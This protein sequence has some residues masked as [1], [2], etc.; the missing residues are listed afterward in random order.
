MKKRRLTP[1]S[2]ALKD[3]FQNP[4]SSL[5]GGY[6]LCRLIYSWKDIAGESIAKAGRPV[7]FKKHELTIAV[8]SSCHLQELQFV[9]EPLRQK[10]NLR[11]P[12]REV[13]SIRLKIQNEKPINRKWA[14]KLFP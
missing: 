11:F 3:I 4:S 8:P 7:Q 2:E 9:K 13:K 1:V 5:S 6:F 10:I 12:D 14:K